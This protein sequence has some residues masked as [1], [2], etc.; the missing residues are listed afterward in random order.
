MEAGGGEEGGVGDEETK[1]GGRRTKDEGS[2]RVT[3][4][5]EEGND[6]GMVRAVLRD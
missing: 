3:A 4:S 1:D 5:R 2:L 6:V